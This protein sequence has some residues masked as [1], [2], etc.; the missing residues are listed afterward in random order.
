MHAVDWFP[1]I[2]ALTGFS[3]KEDLHW[4]GVNQWPALIQAA[5]VDESRTI[6]IAAR[7]AQSIHRGDWKLIRSRDRTELYRIATDPYEKKECAAQNPEVVSDLTAA[8]DVELSKDKTTLPED[9]K[10]AHP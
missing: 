7:S 8:L 1:T 2:A 6:Y 9:L 3:S 5:P 10:G 4:D